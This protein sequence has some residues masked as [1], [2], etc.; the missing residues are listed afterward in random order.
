MWVKQ[1]GGN[2]DETVG[3]FNFD[4]YGNMYIVGSNASLSI[5]FDPSPVTSYTVAATVG[6][7]EI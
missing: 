7:T 2:G 5:D 1:I 6:F 3:G 4:N